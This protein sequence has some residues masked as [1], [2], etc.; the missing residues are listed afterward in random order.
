MNGLCYCFCIACLYEWNL[1]MISLLFMCICFTAIVQWALLKILLSFVAFPKYRTYILNCFCYYYIFALKLFSFC[2]Y[3]SYCNLMVFR[4]M[5]CSA[6]IGFIFKSM[7]R[8][9]RKQIRNGLYLINIR[10]YL[11]YYLWHLRLH[12]SIINM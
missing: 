6:V 8:F 9:R 4:T 12:H 10:I 1:L 11:Q 7:R 5:V 2:L 3:Y